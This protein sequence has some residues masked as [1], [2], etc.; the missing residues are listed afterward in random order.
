M[1]AYKA[2]KTAVLAGALTLAAGGTAWAEYPEK[3]IRI[4]VPTDPGGAIDGLVRIFQRAFEE[5]QILKQPVVVVNMPGAGG[6][7]GTRAIKDAEPDGYTIG[8]WHT[9]LVTSAAMGVTD[10]DQGAFSIIGSTGFVQTGLGVK[11]DSRVAS[12]ADLLA[13]AK[14]GDGNIKVAINVGLPVHFIPLMV[15]EANG[16]GMR[17]VQA[18][19][20]AKRL[21]SVLGG[22]TDTA[23]F[24]VQEL[25]KFQEAGL[26]P[27][28][29]FS[30]E[31]VPEL[32]DVPT[33]RESGIDVLASDARVWLAP[34]GVPADRLKVLRDAFVTA[35]A[36]ESVRT[37]LES[38]GI[39]PEFVDTEAVVAEL[40]RVRAEVMPLV[41]KVKEAAQ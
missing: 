31:R 21:A 11:A 15:S 39:T 41:A 9:G 36:S 2:V 16:G 23:L 17:M 6:T 37:Q 35:M 29:V 7:V 32:P 5:Q 8:L 24:S 12:F 3:P 14:Q 1:K 34:A 10:Y 28:V 27:V 33:A 22:H 26:K 38:Y 13:M 19:G 18:G 30:E 25:L 20:G 4:I 40:N